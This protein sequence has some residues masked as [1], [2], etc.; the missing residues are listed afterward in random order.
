M[1]VRAMDLTADFFGI[2]HGMDA[3]HGREGDRV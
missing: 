2:N 3:F 1:P